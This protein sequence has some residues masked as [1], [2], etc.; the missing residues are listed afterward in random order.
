MLMKRISIL[1]LLSM[2]F[3]KYKVRKGHL[4]LFWYCLAVLPITM[5]GVKITI[6][7]VEWSASLFSSVNFSFIYFEALLLATCTLMIALSSWKIVLYVY[8]MSLFV[9]WT[10]FV[11][12]SVLS[13]INIPAFL[14]L[15]FTRCIIFHP[16]AF[17]LSVFMV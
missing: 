2:M 17:T 11:L 1:L 16:F 10:N 15:L 8:S 9:F 6:I 5:R 14:W 4:C 12:K 3:Y 7:V 13:N